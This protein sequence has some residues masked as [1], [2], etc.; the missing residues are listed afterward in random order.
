MNMRYV[1]I[2]FHTLVK[3][4]NLVLIHFVNFWL[5]NK[6]TAQIATKNHSY[7]IINVNS[8]NT[9]IIAIHRM[10]ISRNRIWIFYQSRIRNWQFHQS[11]IQIPDL[12]P[13]WS[14]QEENSKWF[15]LQ[16][17]AWRCKH[18]VIRYLICIL[19]FFEIFT[20]WFFTCTRRL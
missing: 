12:A 17:C 10:F 6:Q 16:T 3:I 1:L 4:K 5:E 8:V 9:N 20:V 13:D 7:P 19:E 14:E 18:I 2:H 11:W 15:F